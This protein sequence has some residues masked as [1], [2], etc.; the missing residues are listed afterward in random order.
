MAERA[1][2]GPYVGPRPFERKDEALFFGREP[3]SR[4]LLSRVIAHHLVV[5]YAQ[6]GA[7]KTSLLNARVVPR[8]ESKGLQVL[9]ARVGGERPKE[10]DTTGVLN[11]YLLGVLL[12]LLDKGTDPGEMVGQSL[13]GFLERREHTT[14]ASGQPQPRVLI[15]DQFEEL[16]TLYPERWA[17]REEFFL[18]LRQAV[19]QDSLL[20][21][22]LAIRDEYMAHVE[23]FLRLIPEGLRT[24][25]RIE[26]LDEPAALEAVTGPL[27]NTRRRFADG[28]AETLVRDLLRTRVSANGMDGL[29]GEFVEPV[30]L[31][32]VCQNL[33]RS[34]SPDIDVITQRHLSEFGDVDQ[35][36]ADFYERIVAKAASETGTDEYSLRELCENKLITPLGTR[37]SVVR[38]TAT[39]G[40]I[41]NEA[42]E[43]L[44]REHLVRAEWRADAHWYELT[45]DRLIEPIR[46]SN[47]DAKAR[48]ARQVQSRNRRILVAMGV[49]GVV[50]ALLLLFVT[51][52]VAQQRAETDRQARIA[53]SRQFAARVPAALAANPELGLL[54]AMES[55]SVTYSVDGSY[56][57]EAY[58]ALWQALESPP[59]ALLR[60][61]TA[62]VNW[63]AFGPDEQKIVTASADGTARLWDIHG[64]PLATLTGHTDAL[65]RACFSPDGKLV[66]T[67]SA[68]STARLWVEDGRQVALLSGHDGAV[69]DAVFSEDGHLILTASADWTARVWDL[70][71]NCVAVLSGHTGAVNT[72]L[73]SPDGQLVLTSS[74]DGTARLWRLDGTPVAVITGHRGSVS[75]ADLSPDGQL[76]VTAS[77]D[78]RARVWDLTG[79]NLAV[80]SGHTKSV[81]GASFS[82]DGQRIV[83]ASADGTARLWDTNGQPVLIL[84]EHPGPVNYAA[85]SPD[86]RLIVTASADGNVRLWHRDGQAL[87]TL[88]GRNAEAFH[89]E[90]SPDSQL[91]V[92]GKAGGAARLHYIS[93]EQMLALARSRVTRSLTAEELQTYGADTLVVPTPKPS[94]S[95]TATSA[96]PSPTPAPTPSPTAP[97]GMVLVPAG[98]FSMG[99]TDEDIDELFELCSTKIPDCERESLED[100]YP[101]RLVYLDSFYID[102]FE[103]TNA[104][105][106]QCV[107]GGNC[108]ESNPSSRNR[109]SY[110][111]NPEYDQYPVI[112]VSWFDAQAYCEWAGK[113]LPT[114]A[115]WEKAA[116][117]TDA[118]LYPWG[119]EAPD[120]SRLN[121][122]DF[123]CRW[124]Q[125]R[126]QDVHDGYADTSPVGAYPMGT[127]PYGA[128][129]M[130]GNAWEWVADWYDS[131]YYAVAPSRNPLGPTV[132]AKRVLR[133][134]SF[135]NIWHVTSATYR[136]HELPRTRTYGVGFRCAASI[137]TSSSG[138]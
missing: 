47:E 76:V 125:F 17:Q 111:A 90:F 49:A 136:S 4:E 11:P 23:R 112:R 46:K 87:G 58:G 114:E 101:Q 71:G 40:G 43:V 38:E 25:F 68:D 117:G 64:A 51:S 89:A 37:G 94:P 130:A 103:V 57:V 79:R 66:L 13:A 81:V 59:Y 121:Y 137:T 48:H 110:Y 42:I 36:L 34:L 41:P 106:A 52:Q 91:V 32:V 70:E 14:D 16:F 56:T 21:V 9:C 100:Q 27:R 26:R 116:R 83:T 96:A 135:E 39:S 65:T 62:R 132:G 29:P 75:D 77:A 128:C 22:V 6:S 30:Q 67:A 3:E 15:V 131:A 120:A 107:R 82:P 123:D 133:G 2:A 1:E 50:A 80:L 119:N 86:G 60:G 126:D 61:H 10:V 109:S 129:D 72:G 69:N 8:L 93:V 124:K 55:L 7:G 134:G 104:Q 138:G 88:S 122:C 84:G 20:R 78:N 108:T 45:H 63:A 85:F 54:L 12:S 98:D 5:F 105:Y 102:E 118:R 24:R 44:E 35:V 127:S 99:S 31:Q 95:P 97:T 18:E 92:A 28:V 113:R 19:R 74:A 73:F 115:E 53:Q 33:W